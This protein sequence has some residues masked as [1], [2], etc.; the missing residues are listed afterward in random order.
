MQPDDGGCI[1]IDECALQTDSCEKNEFC[2]N[3]DGSFEC[4]SNYT[5]I[6]ND[7]A[8]I[9]NSNILYR[10]CLRL[11]KYLECDRSCDGCSGDGPDLCN[12]CAEGYELRDGLCTGMKSCYH[13]SFLVA[14]HQNTYT[15]STNSFVLS[16]RFSYDF[17]NLLFVVDTRSF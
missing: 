8:T 9:L 2:V 11:T 5:L 1:D 6:I 3:N 16:W 14:H 4:L 17:W 12:N 10:N 7:I 15:F 13:I